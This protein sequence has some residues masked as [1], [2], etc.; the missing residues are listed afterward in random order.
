MN[1][2]IVESPAKAK[3]IGKYLGKDYTVLASFGHVRDLPSKSGSVDPDKDFSM[4]WQVSPDSK[5]HV[6]EICKAV[7]TADH[8][9]L[10]TDPDREGEAISWHIT[11][12]LQEK[13]LLKKIKPERISFNAITK[14]T[15]LDALK[16][17]RDVDQDLVEAYLARLSL[18]YLVGFTLSPVLWRKLPGTKSAGRVQSVTLR[19]VVDREIE[20][21]QFKPQEYWT[22]DSTFTTQNDENFKAR[23]THLGGKKLDRF[24]INSEDKAMSALKLIEAQSYKVSSVEKKRV[25]RNPRPP[26]I[27]S[28]LQQEASRK[29]GFGAKKTMQIAQKLYE[30][31]DIGGEVTGLITYMRTDSIQ[32]E[33][34]AVMS[35]RDVIEQK[36]GKEYV[37]S[38]PRMYKS[39]LKNAQEAHEAIRPTVLSRDPDSLRDRL[40]NDQMRLYELIWKRMMASQM[41]SAEV[42]QTSVDILSD[43]GKIT[44][45]ANGS[46]IA[47]DGFLKLYREGLDEGQ[48]DEDETNLLP[49][50]SENDP[51]DRKETTPLQKFTLPP[52]RYTE[53]SLIKKMEELSIGRPSTYTR[54]I[55]VLYDRGYVR[56]EK[57]Q[58]YAEDRGRIL[59]A[60]LLNYFERY[61]QYNFTAELEEELDNI[62][63]GSLEWKA[64]LNQFWKDFIAAID[65]AKDLS[66]QEVLEHLQKDLEDH[67]FPPKADGSNSHQ[68]PD[69]KDGLLNLRLGRF[70]PFIACSSYPECKYTRKLTE[71]DSE[72]ESTEERFE[73]RE[74]GVDPESELPVRVKKGPYGFYV[75]WG[76]AAKGKKPK[77][78]GLPK[79]Q[80]PNTFTLEQAIS[81]GALPRDVGIHPESSEMITAG[82]GRFGPYIKHGKTYVSLKGDDNVLT[83]GLNRAVVLIAENA[84]KPKQKK[85]A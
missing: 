4:I 76:D 84:K 67:L 27:T 75:Q 41:A 55:Q 40:D 31:I 71:G 83:I 49:A 33:P 52:P 3:T 46:I 2:V 19:L 20:I 28:T 8:V 14:S 24:D 48:K 77:R 58:L 60:F 38:S 57:R 59:T 18:D 7:K 62:S 68:C 61:V 51:A 21:D 10:A 63:N 53:A 65:G 26:F 22:L 25:K 56:A 81:L 35:S 45:R 73:K 11:E 80:D 64:V 15:V 54:T 44:F 47:F 16:A 30:G 36:F 37:P 42:D 82:I 39:K 32:V 69:C 6:A 74:L 13:G 1:V 9:Y 5:K 50:L 29:L 17:P 66:I 78:A 70:G 43:D 72:E 23:L 85:K 12:M 79:G 34:A